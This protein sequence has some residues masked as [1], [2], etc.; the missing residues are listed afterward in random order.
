MPYACRFMCVGMLLLFSN[1]IAHYNKI[2]KTRKSTVWFQAIF[3]EVTFN[4]DLRLV[5][6]VYPKNE[7]VNIWVISSVIH[8]LFEASDSTYAK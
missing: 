7:N 4:I 3:F 6:S 1:E 5:K 2:T 8:L